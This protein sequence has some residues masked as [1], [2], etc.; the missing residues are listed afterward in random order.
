MTQAGHTQFSTPEMSAIFSGGSLVARML[1][2]EA[3]LA[4]AQARAGLIAEE[5]AKA[6]ASR[7]NVE[8]FDIAALYRDAAD[9]GTPAIPLVR[10]LTERVGG[11][12]GKFVHWGATSQDAID[13]ATILQIRD[14]L[15]LLIGR[16]LDVA[17]GCGALA[18]RHRHTPMAGRTLLQH[19]V[20]ITFGLKAAR[21][22]AQSTRLV[23]S[24]R[25][26]Q[27]HALVV[28][29]G[30][31]AGTLAALGSA[32]V[33]VMELL[34]AEL[35]LG[36]PDL[37]WHTERDRMAEVASSLGIV[38]G[39]MGKIASDISLL[40]QTEVGEVTETSTGAAGRSSTMPHKRNPVEAT[41]AMAC[42]RLALG[43]VPT[44]LSAAVQEHE[45]AV[46]GWQAEWQAVPDL[47]RFTAGAV[48]WVHRALGHLQVDA[49]RMRANLD[50]TRG[51]IM[52][53]A[54]TMALA[55]SLGRPEAYRIAQRLSDRAAQTG[56]HLKDLAA[57]DQQ[58]QSALGRE[59][60]AK[61]F[62][63]S[64]YLG[65]TDALIDRALAG[66]RTVR[67]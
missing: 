54:L 50:L 20:P 49:E 64:T 6:I 40:T 46:G 62:D 36:A 13:T 5:A 29:L 16:L 38:A 32:G 33:S 48:E 9:A 22:L 43:V 19:A 8:L 59:V 21:W 60:I 15:R 12:A 34:A 52:A 44:V 45:R 3:A 39:A 56:A 58:V 17:A 27:D 57:S 10:M 66:F 1:E 30:G 24:L 35:K 14:G 42:A 31:A 47:F 37:P 55:P 61:V 18:E 25:R 67:E 11:D 23:Q 4:R 2:F 26:L 65:S 7:C 41:A 53:E 28:Q 63:A 51:L